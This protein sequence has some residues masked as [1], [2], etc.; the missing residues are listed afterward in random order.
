MVFASFGAADA[1]RVVAPLDELVV[2]FLRPLAPVIAA[3]LTALHCRGSILGASERG[4]GN[5]T[6]KG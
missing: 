5:G 6:E 1:N 2:A 3:I 4:A